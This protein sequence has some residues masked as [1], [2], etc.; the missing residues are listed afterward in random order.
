MASL[1]SNPQITYYH[2]QKA[3]D[4]LND[5]I[6]QC[7]A[8]Q[9]KAQEMNCYKMLAELYE[10]LKDWEHTTTF[11]KLYYTLKGEIYT[12]DAEDRAKNF[13]FQRITDKAQKEKQIEIAKLQEKELLLHDI[14]PSR[15]AER[16]VHGEKTIAE[17]KNNVSVIFMDIVGFTPISQ[18]L[19]AD[20]IVETLNSLYSTFD[21]IAHTFG[22]EKIKTN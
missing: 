10:Y 8:L 14:L 12:R 6:I 20:I 5:C 9:L 16:I 13:D 4:M 22:I 15:I 21:D 2:P 1:Y 7:K 17:F 18:A 11:Y 3:K 19:S